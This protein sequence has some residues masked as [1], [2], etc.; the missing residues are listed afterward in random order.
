[1]EKQILL[2]VDELTL[3]LSLVDKAILEDLDEW[4]EKAESMISEF[5]G[6]ANL[7][8]VFGSQRNL[9][10]KCPQGYTV[11]YQYG[12]QPFY[13]AVAYHP[14][15]PDMGVIIKF[16]AHGWSVYSRSNSM[17]IKRFLKSVKS[18]MYNF[19]LSRVD[20]AVDYQ[21]WD[22]TVDDIYQ[23]LKAH[24][25]EIRD[26]N[27]R[28][29]TSTINAHEVDG[30][31]DTF[32]VGSR[33]TGTR[34][35]LRVYDKKI[36]QLEK[37]GFRMEEALY[38]TSWVRF[39]AVYKGKYAHQLTD[40]IMQTEEEKL[41]HLIADKVSEKFRFYDLRSE[42]LL[43]FSRAL[44]ERA[45]MDF[46]RLR[47]E[48]PRDNGLMSL[49]SHLVN[50]SGLFSA[51]YKCDEIWGEKTAIVLLEHLYKLYTEQYEPNDDVK[52]WLKKHKDSMKEQSFE[53]DLKMLKVLKANYSKGAADDFTE[54]NEV[55]NDAGQT[56]TDSE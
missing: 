34:L 55:M 44:L 49:L 50:G 30:V 2:G 19:R 5:A 54:E 52:Y 4:Q 6:L 28:K 36:E 38:T 27:G 23:N 3:V 26:Y 51:M 31:A 53:G 25:L 46:E 12:D 24:N 48:S 43:D 39:E 10:D 8:T 16:S 7:E 20:F 33:K 35:F 22:F 37:R 17:N 13:F 21:N 11:G 29:N 9:E 56:S 42:K 40:I 47:L 41:S 1:M 45:N 14:L 18:D 15:H 32:Y